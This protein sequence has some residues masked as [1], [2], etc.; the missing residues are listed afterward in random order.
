MWNLRNKTMSLLK[1]ERE[2]ETRNRPLTEN[3]LMVSRGE[4]G[5]G[6]G[7]IGDGDSRVHFS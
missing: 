7:E 5:E 1:R 3:K 4:V 6:I 2:R